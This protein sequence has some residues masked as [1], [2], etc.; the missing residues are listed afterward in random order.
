ME[1]STFEVLFTFKI[2]NI[3]VLGV[4]GLLSLLSIDILPC[5]LDSLRLW[6]GDLKDENKMTKGKLT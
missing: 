2:E 6:G 3:K 4:R 5:F 1:P